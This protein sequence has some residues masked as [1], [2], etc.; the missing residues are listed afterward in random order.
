MQCVAGIRRGG[1]NI[2][3][4]KPA[5]QNV[6][7]NP[8]ALDPGDASVGPIPCDHTPGCGAYLSITDWIL[9]QK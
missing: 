8:W 9:L 5:M 2:P 1:R 4:V 6:A 3:S 7:G